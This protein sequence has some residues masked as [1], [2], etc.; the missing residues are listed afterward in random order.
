MWNIHECKIAPWIYFR[1]KFHFSEVHGSMNTTVMCKVSD[2]VHHV[3]CMGPITFELLSELKI[4]TQWIT[5]KVNDALF[6][7]HV[8]FARDP[9]CSYFMNLR[10]IKF[11]SYSAGEEKSPLFI[12]LHDQLPF[13]LEETGRNSGKFLQVSPGNPVF[14]PG[15]T[16][17][18]P[19]NFKILPI[20]LHVFSEKLCY[21]SLKFLW[22]ISCFSLKF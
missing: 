13:F 22:E 7:C 19:W 14:S 3:N 16:C 11:I 20:K 4:W 5:C 15:N 12:F 6:G 1:N 9:L 17:I 18:S 8:N 2:E 21:F 10:K